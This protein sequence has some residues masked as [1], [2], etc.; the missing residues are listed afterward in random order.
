MPFPISIK[1][2]MYQMKN[3]HVFA[4][5]PVII[6][7]GSCSSPM[8]T[9]VISLSPSYTGDVQFMQKSNGLFPLSI[10]AALAQ[11]H[12]HEYISTE[13]P[14]PRMKFDQWKMISF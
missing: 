11:Q 6:T 4:L 13:T 10:T 3:V 2:K 9:A 1:A 14:G 5:C 12:K 7:C 8:V